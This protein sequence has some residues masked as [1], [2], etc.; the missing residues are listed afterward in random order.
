MGL[1]SYDTLLEAAK[2]TDMSESQFI[3][4]ATLSAAASLIEW[5][6]RGGDGEAVF[7]GTTSVIL[8]DKKDG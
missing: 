4:W 3:R 5:H 6:R 7:T 1:A 8:T 2:M